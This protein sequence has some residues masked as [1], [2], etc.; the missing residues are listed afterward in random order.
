MQFEA[1]GHLYTVELTPLAGSSLVRC[2]VDGTEYTV[3]AQNLGAGRWLLRHE[4]QQTLVHSASV[5]NGIALHLN[6]QHLTL[7]RVNEHAPRRRS[8]AAAGD[9]NAPMPGQVTEVHVSAGERVTRGQL[10]LMMEAM[11]MEIRVTAPYDGLVTALHVQANDL[12]QRGQILVD[13]TSEEIT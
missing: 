3:D 13:L 1:Q 12:V 8:A 7:K 11:K 4:G 10:L 9:L 5:E 6:G 2:V